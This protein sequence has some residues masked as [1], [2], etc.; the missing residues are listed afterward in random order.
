MLWHARRDSN[1]QHSEPESDALSI[2]L[3]THAKRSFRALNYYNKDFLV[4]K[5]KVC[6]KNR[7][8]SCIKKQDFCPLFFPFY[9]DSDWSN[10]RAGALRL[11]SNSFYALQA[12][13]SSNWLLYKL[14]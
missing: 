13:T 3:R 9:F 6:A 12:E 11:P 5:E 4:C 2:E 14:A 7:L 8:F 1:P 10:L